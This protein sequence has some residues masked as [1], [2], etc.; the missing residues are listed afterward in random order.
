MEIIFLR[1]VI[2]LGAIISG[3]YRFPVLCKP[4]E[5]NAAGTRPS[6]ITDQSYL[7]Q[8]VVMIRSESVA[9]TGGLNRP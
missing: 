7:K 4:A 1:Q 3:L 9:L 2:W 8:D 6:L 5:L